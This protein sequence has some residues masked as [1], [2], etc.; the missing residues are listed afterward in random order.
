MKTIHFQRPGESWVSSLD[1]MTRAEFLEKHPR[2]P[3]R[4]SDGTT[5]KEFHMPPNVIHC[6]FCNVD[7][8]EVGFG[9]S[10]SNGLD[11]V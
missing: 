7:P 4:S 8:G 9:S 6:D 3:L 11:V 10:F 1:E 5:V 2:K